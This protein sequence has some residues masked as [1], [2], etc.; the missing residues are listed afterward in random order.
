MTRCTG[1]R[2][3]NSVGVEPKVDVLRILARRRFTKLPASVHALAAEQCVSFSLAHAG[4]S[5]FTVCGTCPPIVLP[6]PVEHW[7][8][9]QP[10]AGHGSR[11]A[12]VSP[13]RFE[14]AAR[15]HAV[16]VSVC[17]IRQETCFINAI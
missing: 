5:W 12:S 8:F 4:S 15:K 2:F 7:V 16:S 6:V 9:R 3:D 11:A 10:S 13:D 17:G 1:G 14:P